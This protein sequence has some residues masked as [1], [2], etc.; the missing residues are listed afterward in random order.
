ML[1]KDSSETQAILWNC[2]S[3]G[4]YMWIFRYPV[5]TV[6]HTLPLDIQFASICLESYYQCWRLVSWRKMALRYLISVW[7]N[8][9]VLGQ[10][11]GRLVGMKP[12]EQL[13]WRAS[14]LAAVVRSVTHSVVTDRMQNGALCTLS[15]ELSGGWA[16][17]CWGWRERKV[18]LTH[19]FHV[20]SFSSA[21]PEDLWWQLK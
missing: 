7:K 6:Q 16:L 14:I 5:R 9:P 20:V 1:L 17:G 4:S 8:V 21:T 2:F 18:T 11:W 13:L 3:T 19:T 10:E 15:A 12:S